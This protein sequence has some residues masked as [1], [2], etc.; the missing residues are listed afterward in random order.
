MAGLVMGTLLGL[1]YVVVIPPVYRA[2]AQLYVPSQDEASFARILLGTT[3]STPYSALVGVLRSD[4]MAESLAKQFKRPIADV[5]RSWG[6]LARVESSQIDVVAEHTSREVAKKHVEASLDFLRSLDRRMNKSISSAKSDQLLSVRDSKNEEFE[7]KL[8]AFVDKWSELDVPVDGTPESLNQLD[9]LYVDL[10]GDFKSQESKVEEIR[11][12]RTLALQRSDLPQSDSLESS[13]QRVESARQTMSALRDTYGDQHP[14]MVEARSMLKEAEIIYARE[15]AKTKA[16][17]IREL[18][19]SVYHAEV[20]RDAARAK[21]EAFRT[22]RQRATSMNAEMSEVRRELET[23]AKTL[24]SVRAE[25]E[26]T[27]LETETENVTWAVLTP[28]YVED[29]PINKR[30]AR[31]P[32][33]AG[34]IGLAL[35]LI[36][37]SLRR[38]S[39]S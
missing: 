8:T 19:T 38:G 5:R 24:A 16:G 21:V 22:M 26:V 4:A 12:R 31:Y 30:Y 20:D 10:E 3:T 2:K 33:A 17:V 36:V 23:T 28:T 27:R 9:L 11:S 32:V 18:D 13:R 29:R 34:A 15:V 35:G 14:K 39:R 1:V 25:Y 6:V 37:S 7:A